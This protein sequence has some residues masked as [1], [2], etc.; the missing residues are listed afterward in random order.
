MQAQNSPQS[1]PHL[2]SY[3]HLQPKQVHE[4]LEK[5]SFQEEMDILFSSDIDDLLQKI[6]ESDNTVNVLSKL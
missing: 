4:N 3:L 2:L 6:M 1:L 5:H